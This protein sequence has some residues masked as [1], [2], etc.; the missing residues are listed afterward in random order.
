MKSSNISRGGFFRNVVPRVGRTSASRWFIAGAVCGVVASTVFAASFGFSGDTTLGTGSVAVTQCDSDVTVEI[1]SAYDIA[2]SA[3]TVSAITLAGI[4]S[5]CANKRLRLVGYSGSVTAIDTVT[6]LGA[7]LGWESTITISPASA[8]GT[9]QLQ[10]TA[11][12]IKD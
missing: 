3:F 11:L 5:G 4:D 12:E 8:I 6:T 10:G 9:D 2:S 1:G 7:S